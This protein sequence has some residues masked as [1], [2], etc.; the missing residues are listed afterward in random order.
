MAGP[1]LLELRAI[2]KNFGGVHALEGVSFGIKAGEVVALVGHN[3]AGKSVLVQI[4][5][6]VFQPTGG[7][8]VI[9][10]QQ[11][12]LANPVEA[13]A[14]G[15]ETIY[16]TLALADNLDA[17][18]NFFLGRELRKALGFLDKKAMSR[19]AAAALAKL[20]PNF[21]DIE[22]PVR[23][24]SGGQ[25]QA[26]AIARAIHFNVRLLIMDEPTAALGPHETEQVEDLIRRLKGQGIAILLV[27]HDVRSVIDLADRI[28]VLKNGRKVGEVSA[29][30][31]TEDSVVDMIVRG[32]A[33]EAR[34][35]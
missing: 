25:R 32:A 9:D 22:R 11:K 15:I 3:G 13:R 10:R 21:T 23:D 31:A 33:R 20:N 27:S 17:P 2:T 30:A 12:A 5:S 1:Y 16:Q 4:L 35:P 7:E 24:M 34:A 28:V 18:S 6:G 26:I 8:I 19:Q 29:G 14:I